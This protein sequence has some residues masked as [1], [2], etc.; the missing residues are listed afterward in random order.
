LTR[1]APIPLIRELRT[2]RR[3][4][5][6]AHTRPEGKAMQTDERSTPSAGGSTTALLSGKYEQP[7]QEFTRPFGEG[8]SSPTKGVLIQRNTLNQF[9]SLF[10][11]MISKYRFPLAACGAFSIANSLLLVRILS[12]RKEEEMDEVAIESIVSYLQDL[13]RVTPE[14]EKV[15]KAISK[16]REAYV[17]AHAS[18]FKN[19][20]ERKKYQS[21]WVANYEISDYLTQ[22]KAES[23]EGLG[24]GGTPAHLH[25]FRYNQWPERGDAKH[26]EKARMTEEKPFGGESLGDKATVEM[27]KGASRFIIESFSP[28]RKLRR[29]GAWVT[30]Q[31]DTKTLGKNHVFLLDVNGHFVTSFAC[32]LKRDNDVIPALVVINTTSSSY[33]SNGAP[34]AA[35]DAAFPSS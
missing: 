24:E 31:R 3:A 4:F 29:P 19:E 35:F 13:T 15:M 25:F 10:K 14:V 23:K 22:T 28:S 20:R 16:W 26:E 7:R 8:P 32:R 2:T 34:A 18:D 21:D 11:P 9:D 17:E 12:E 27:E 1:A 5:S 33:L 30:L 6:P